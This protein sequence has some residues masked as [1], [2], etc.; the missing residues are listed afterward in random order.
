MSMVVYPKGCAVVRRVAMEGL[1]LK[2][3]VAPMPATNAGGRIHRKDLPGNVRSGKRNFFFSE[4]PPSLRRDLQLDDE[5]MYSVTNQQDA[6]RMTQLISEHLGGRSAAAAAIVTDGTAC[7]GGNAMSFA[8]AFKHVNA[9]EIDPRRSGMLA[10]N[11]GVLGLESQ[12]SVYL[13]DFVEGY[14]ELK[15]DCIFLDPPW[16]GPQAMHREGITFRL[17]GVPLPELCG[18]LRPHC[19]VLCIKLSPN[20][21]LAEFDG[22][23]KVQTLYGGFRKMLLLVIEF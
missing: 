8:K 7:V 4:V 2:K 12:V 16:G 17:G 14:S 15:Q 20:Y 9:V 23:G 10:R 21:D 19:R 11:V 13:G 3:L 6:D 18:R 5:A 22:A 1:K